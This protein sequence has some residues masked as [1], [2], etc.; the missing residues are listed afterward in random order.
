MILNIFDIRAINQANQ[1]MK[2][3]S[4]FS[5][6][7][8]YISLRNLPERCNLIVVGILYFSRCIKIRLQKSVEEE[9]IGNSPLHILCVFVD[10]K[11][12]YAAAGKHT[13]QHGA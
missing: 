10:E 5:H 6:F 8:A 12:I 3:L 13:I 4:F 2:I 7:L 9:T 11:R 1:L